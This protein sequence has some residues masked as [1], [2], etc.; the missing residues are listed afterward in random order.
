[1]EQI[2]SRL[3]RA[4]EYVR[5][6]GYSPMY[7]SL[8][9]SQNYGLSLNGEEYCSDYDFKCI[10]FP[11][12]RDITDEEA[13]A[14]L[15]VDF[16]GGQIDV[17]DI[18]LFAKLLE[19]MNP[20]YLEC[21]MTEN[22]L[23]LGDEDCVSQMRT[24]V[25]ALFAERGAD[26]ARVCV[27]L[28]EEKAKRLCHISPA[29]AESIARYGYEPKQAHHM[30]RLLVMLREFERTGSMQLMAPEQEKTL[31]LDLKR[32]RYSLESICGMIGKWRSELLDTEAR[33]FSSYGK[34][35]KTAS[36]RI[37]RICRDAV[38]EHCRKEV[39]GIGKHP[40]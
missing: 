11:F 39:L 19:K 23:V 38:Y 35:A 5:G 4:G 29:Q 10:V 33:I 25:P 36:R 12:L 16:E 28:F 30:Y 22:C 40:L 3:Q 2:A 17:K 21:L 15:T 13:P 24:L 27:K 7:V 32:G 18:R 26:F 6:L 1:V 37:Q 14:S 31:L 34:P 9:G 8:Y 20:A